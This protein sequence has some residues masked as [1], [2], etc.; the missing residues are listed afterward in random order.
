M[1]IIVSFDLC[2]RH[3]SGSFMLEV[4]H[5]MPYVTITLTWDDEFIALTL[6]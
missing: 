3:E 6:L 1:A 2:Q 5:N 4:L